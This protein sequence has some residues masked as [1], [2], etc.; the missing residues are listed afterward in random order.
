VHE[1]PPRLPGAG[2]LGT[3]LAATMAK[4]PASRWSAA[5]VC[6]FLD[7]VPAHGRDDTVPLTPLRPPRPLGP[8]PPPPVLAPEPVAPP[9]RAA[10]G[11]RR[12]PLLWPIVACLLVLILVLG[13]WL[14]GRTGSHGPAQT[15]R[16]TGSATHPSSSSPS[17]TPSTSQPPSSAAPTGPTAQGMTSFVSRYLDTVTRDPRTAFAML[18]PAFQRASGGWSS[19][20]S[21]WAPIHGASL[22]DVRADPGAMTVSY[23]VV[24][25]GGRRRSLADDVTLRLV[26]RD[27]HY[28]IDGEPR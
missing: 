3:V 6:A 4:D 28:L 18:T 7:S 13:A 12:T 17:T 19:Y 11:A 8:V 20:H 22:S 1:D 27:G 9:S 5:Q 10:S 16:G 15:A 24:Y 23:H 26:Y 21:W 25:D 2:A 14:V